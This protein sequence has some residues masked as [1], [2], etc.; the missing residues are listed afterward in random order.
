LN[1]S[2]I[3]WCMIQV[4]PGLFWMPAFAANPR[5]VSS[6]LTTPLLHHCGLTKVKRKSFRSR[7]VERINLINAFC[8]RERIGHDFASLAGVAAGSRAHVTVRHRRTCRTFIVPRASNHLLILKV[9]WIRLFGSMQIICGPATVAVAAIVRSPR[10]LLFE[11]W[12]QSAAPAPQETLRAGAEQNACKLRSA[13]GG[14]VAI[15]AVL[16]DWWAARRC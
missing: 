9:T 12:L 6:K 3:L 11:V 2:Q 16:H 1:W 14:V 8:F 7:A 15:L 10:L 5:D 4:K 13:S